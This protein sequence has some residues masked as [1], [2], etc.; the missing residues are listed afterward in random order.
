MYR[1]IIKR[2]LYNMRDSYLIYILAC[3]FAI[4]IYGTLVSLGS[5]PSIKHAIPLW[6]SLLGDISI[7][8]SWLF[9]F[10]A[11]LYMV[12]VGGFFVKQQ[13][14]EFM[15][16]EKLGMQRWII[17]AI[18]F[19]QTAVVQLF[20]W[21]IGLCG[22][23]VFQKF[24]GMML[25]YL[26]N[27]KVNFLMH[28]DLSDVTFLMKIFIYSTL[29]F[30]SINAFK[31]MRI[32]QKGKKRKVF[33]IRWW[34]RIPAGL[35]GVILLVAAQFW[36]V[37]LVY[38]ISSVSYSPKPAAEISFILVADVFGTYLV[39][40]GFL[41]TILNFLQRNRS[42]AYSGINLFSFKYLKERLFQNISTL[43]F[44]TELSAMALVLLTFCYYGYQTVHRNYNTI[45]PFELSADQNTVKLIRKELKQSNAKIVD[46]YHS[47]VKI[48]LVSY[49]KSSSED[50]VKQPMTFMSYSS[51]MALPK[52]IRKWN[53]KIK[54]NEFLKI[55]YN[56]GYLD[57]KFSKVHD[58]EVKGAPL[59]ATAKTGDSFPYGSSLHYGSMMIVPDKYY[60]RLPAEISD[61][62]YG[63]KFKKGD[64]LSAKQLRKLDKYRGDYYIKVNAHSSLE[65]S[66]IEISGEAPKNYKEE[67]YAQTGF[68]RQ[69]GLKQR[70]NQGGGFF[71]FIVSLFSVALLIALGSV[72]TLRILLRDDYQSRQLRILQK[73][74]VEEREIQKIVWKENALTFLIPLVFA[75]MQAIGCSISFSQKVSKNLILIY[76]GYI[77]MYCLFGFASYQISWHGIK[78]KFSL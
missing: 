33:K 46:T 34:I 38:D 45:Y 70:L 19:L 65:N 18:S 3:A 75:L 64:R 6:K 39:Y 55:D 24:L 1:K 27:L 13:H 11:W 43:W 51:Y 76:G 69:G 17:I 57:N 20:A 74:G 72:L 35:F 15:T 36:A 56:S 67:I 29:V 47:D 54:P 53:S 48:S 77:A 25:F 44:V 14:Q 41:P 52:R 32:L 66:T 73:I 10:C 59:I 12:Y 9:A 4:G 62:L 30:S 63:W 60:Q 68:M 71:F 21:I 8:M 37:Q 2:S 50:F 7:M 5:N 23:V 58:I 22:T 49:Y 26:M 42:V 40:Y 61:K 31:T 78:K 28:I 16:F